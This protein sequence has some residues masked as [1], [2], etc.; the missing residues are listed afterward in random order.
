MDNKIISIENLKFQYPNQDNVILNDISFDIFKG[1]W[2]A[3]IGHNGSG[4]STLARLIDGLLKPLSGEIIVDNINLNYDTLWDVR[5][6]IAMVFQN[7]DNQF[8]GADVMSDIAFGLENRGIPREEMIVRVNEALKLVNMEKFAEHD[9]SHLSGGQKQRVA[10]ASAIA[11]EPEIIILD[12]ATSMLDPEGRI[13]LINLINKLRKEKNFT[14][15]SITHDIDEATLADR[16]L[17]LNDGEI[18]TQG[19]PAEVFYNINEM[20][21]LGLDIPYPQKIAN[22]LKKRGYKVPNKYLTR[23]ELID[24]LCQLN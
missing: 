22:E 13:E 19:S 8:V 21:T 12:E 7:P 4:K 16:V 20:N 18:I 10:I 24:W 14:V 3:L 2:I 1:E 15:I 23:S 9:P 6:K 11:L 17:V 5:A